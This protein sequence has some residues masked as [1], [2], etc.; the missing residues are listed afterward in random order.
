MANIVPA[1]L[2]TPYLLGGL[3]VLYLGYK[4][5][6]LVRINAR[7]NKL[8]ARAP[9]RKSYAPLGLDIAY[10]VVSHA[11]K[12]KSYEMWVQMFNK[13]AGPGRY[14]IEAGIG[15]RVI[16]TAEPENIKAILATQF[17]DYGKGEQFRKDWHRFLGNG[18]FTTDGTLWH[19]SRQ[20]IRPQFI[21][22]R[23]SDID[24]FETHTQILLSKISGGQA[25]D[26]MDMMFRYTLDAA[27]H[28]LLGVSVDS[29]ENPQTK[30][31][32]AFGNAQRVQSIIARVGP[33]NWAV[34]RKRMGFYDSID[35]INDFVSTFIDR[36]LAL[37]PEELNEKSNHDSGYTFLHAIA[38]Y[39][40]DRQMLRDQLVSVLLAGRD[41]TAC[42][43]TW[44]IYHLSLSPSIFAKLRQEIIDTVGLTEKPTYQH[45]KD[46]KYLQHVLNETLRLYPV[47]PYNVR[48][49]LKDTTL[50]TG[51]GPNGDQPIGI[52]AGTPI[53]YST[54]VMQ[55]RADLYPGPET[56]FAD[57]THFVPERWNSWT[58]KSWT[59][60]PF[61]G[62]PRICIGQQF[63]LTEMGYTLVR[64]LQRFSGIE[65]LMEDEH[66][67]LHADIVLQPAHEVKVRFVEGKSG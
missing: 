11:L 38:G 67:G 53:G 50:P 66:P 51:G 30:F 39:T 60:I 15:E 12:D 18:I 59:Y 33:L 27:T 26:T 14:T 37:S 4:I 3:I 28:F 20:L 9:L 21:K 1:Q 34:P 19:N 46:M 5:V 25:T 47:V 64:L 56:G 48:M 41:T 29:L 13:W 17:K 22:D 36:A 62:G 6:N 24:I 61:N 10:E 7:I 16:L 63:A 45:L 65:N 54:L 52:L 23:L 40:R 58:P 42:T 31:A 43:L 2:S 44:A 35:T 57:P 8:G 32:D 55:R 49:A